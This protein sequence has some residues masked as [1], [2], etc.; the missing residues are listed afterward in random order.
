MTSKMTEV[1]VPKL[2]FLP[3]IV[4]ERSPVS[5]YFHNMNL[6]YNYLKNILCRII[7]AHHCHARRQWVFQTVGYCYSYDYT[8]SSKARR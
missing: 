1:E 2:G 5:L 7:E 6:N 8:R 3:A 4:I